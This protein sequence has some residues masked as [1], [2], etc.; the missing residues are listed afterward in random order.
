MTDPHLKLCKFIRVFLGA[1]VKLDFHSQNSHYCITTISTFPGTV[2][3][4]WD[5]IY[6]LYGLHLGKIQT[7]P[8]PCFKTLHRLHKR[9]SINYATQLE[10]GVCGS[11]Y[12][13][14]LR[15]KRCYGGCV[16]TARRRD[17]G[18]SGGD[19]GNGLGENG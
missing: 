3:T 10:G 18:C 1:Q 14:G 16:E 19:T 11:V 7:L 6:G 5:R 15:A 12:R 8:G 13:G 2:Y 17:L 9:L 4:P